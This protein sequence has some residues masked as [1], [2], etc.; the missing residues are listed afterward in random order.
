MGVVDISAKSA[1]LPGGTTAPGAS[2]TECANMEE[3]LTAPGTLQ[4][5]HGEGGGT[6]SYTSCSVLVTHD[7]GSAE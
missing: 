5:A 7:I 3:P 4:A 1:P 6:H 2:A